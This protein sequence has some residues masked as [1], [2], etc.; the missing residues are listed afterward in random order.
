MHFK[1]VIVAIILAINV[2]NGDDTTTT[3][4]TTTTSTSTPTTKPSSS[5]IQ[6]ILSKLPLYENIREPMEGI[7][8]PMQSQLGGMF[9]INRNRRSIRPE[10]H[11]NED[12]DEKKFS[13]I[14]RDISNIG[15]IVPPRVNIYPPQG[16]PQLPIPAK[17]SQDKQ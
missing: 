11:P 7:L 14:A 16:F 6:N 5:I 2:V 3:P 13:R 9:G 8:K 1:L 12:E 10:L 15:T 4:A 17:N